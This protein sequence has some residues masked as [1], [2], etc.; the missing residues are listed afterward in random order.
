M[1]MRKPFYV[2]FVEGDD[3]DGGQGGGGKNENGTGKVYEHGYPK[4]TPLVEMSDKEQAA[5]WKFHAR[6]HESKAK[7]RE[8]YDQQKAD[9]DKWRQAQK[10][11]MTPD[12]KAIDAAKEEARIEERRKIAP[13]LVKA[14]FKAQARRVDPDILESFLEDIDSTKYLNADGDVDIDK[15]KAR[16]EKLT[17]KQQQQQQRQNHQGYRKSDGATGLAS[18]RDLYASRTKKNN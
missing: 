12:Q 13:R 17:P 3:P 10:D 16:V 8:D 14:E 7:S 9:A 15:V 11:Q 1:A 18:G 6:Q 5:Y 2:R 4:D